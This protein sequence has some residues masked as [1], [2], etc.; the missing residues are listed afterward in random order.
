MPG[1]VSIPHGWGHD[2]PGVRL[3]VAAAH[4]GVNSNVLADELADRP[5]VGQRRAERDPGRGRAVREPDAALDLSE[6]RPA[7]VAAGHVRVVG[8]PRDRRVG[9]AV[10]AVR[11]QLEAVQAEDAAVAAGQV[12]LA[13]PGLLAGRALR[14]CVGGLFGSP[15]PRP[16]SPLRPARPSPHGLGCGARPPRRPSGGGASCGCASCTATATSGATGRA[17]VRTA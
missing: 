16:A 12:R 7:A 2:A 11:A 4:A 17:S 1:V 10:R 5:A 9:A 3:G 15:R 6:H 14:A 8:H 13:Q